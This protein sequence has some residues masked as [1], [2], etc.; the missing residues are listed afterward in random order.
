MPVWVRRAPKIIQ[1]KT[2]T[3]NWSS[4]FSLTS[5]F[6]FTVAG[7]AKKKTF[8]DNWPLLW[9]CHT[10]TTQRYVCHRETS[11]APSHPR[12]SCSPSRLRPQN[13]LPKNPPMIISTHSSA[14]SPSHNQ[15][16]ATCS[17]VSSH[18]MTFSA[19]RRRRWVFVC[20]VC[21][22]GCSTG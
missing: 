19:R 1:D 9:N 10:F 15:R 18:Q 3:N 12:V 5:L 7:G 8:L 2:M 16:Q 6:R 22:N 11:R 21:Q 4:H 17:F 14:Q 20:V 13:P